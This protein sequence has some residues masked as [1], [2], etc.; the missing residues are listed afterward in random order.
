MSKKLLIDRSVCHQRFATFGGG[1]DPPHLGS[2]ARTLVFPDHDGQLSLKCDRHPFDRA[3][4]NDPT[5]GASSQLSGANRC[6]G[7]EE[8]DLSDVRTYSAKKRASKVD[9]QSEAR[10]PYAG[11]TMRQFL[12]QLPAL[13][14]AEDLKAVARAVVQARD[15][16]KPVIAMLGDKI[17]SKNLSDELILSLCQ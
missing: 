5:T 1:E 6:A 7:T 14:K 17:A 10:A 3:H 15:K 4:N 2:V 11:M 8:L 13:L 9:T 16:K 12:D